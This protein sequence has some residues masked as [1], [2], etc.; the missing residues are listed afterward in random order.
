VDG[1]RGWGDDASG[2]RVFAGARAVMRRLDYT[3]I[4]GTFDKYD[5]VCGY[6]NRV[7]WMCGGPMPPGPYDEGSG[8]HVVDVYYVGGP[9]ECESWC[10]SGQ[11][12]NC[13]VTPVCTED[14]C[15]TPQDERCDGHDNDGGA[16]TDEG[17]CEP[18]GPCQN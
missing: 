16:R 14:A 2:G 18:D 10:P 4:G 17:T 5:C 11:P 8:C 12:A 7:A 1:D 9:S 3:Y 13:D 15:G 6:F